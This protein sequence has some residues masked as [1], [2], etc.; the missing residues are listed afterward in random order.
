M[1]SFCRDNPE[2]FEVVSWARCLRSAPAREE[3]L[4]GLRLQDKA[5]GRWGDSSEPSLR[6]GRSD[7]A[8]RGN[9]LSAAPPP[10]RAGCERAR[11]P[12]RAGGYRGGLG[13][14]LGAPG[15][16]QHGMGSGLRS[17][18]GSFSVPGGKSPGAARGRR[19]ALPR[20]SPAGSRRGKAR[21]REALEGT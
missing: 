7:A 8:P 20:G 1:E 6:S 12:G 14:L 2:I 10:C 21:N 18:L 13:G 17:E 15:S 5:H 11:P 4:A 3:R 9:A 19:D 16:P